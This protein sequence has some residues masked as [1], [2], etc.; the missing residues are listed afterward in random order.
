MLIRALR[1]RFNTVPP[2]A[3]EKIQQADIA[4][5]LNWEEKIV[6]ANTIEEIFF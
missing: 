4:T 6:T 3:I 2:T 1:R 5:L